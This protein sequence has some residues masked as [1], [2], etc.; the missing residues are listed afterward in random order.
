MPKGNRLPVN[1]DLTTIHF[2]ITAIVSIMHRISG[3]VLFLALPFL[4]C[5]F[6]LSVK[7]AD[8]FE[9]VATWLQQPLIKFAT[10]ALI[11]AVVYHILAGI[12]HII[13]DFGFGESFAAGK[14]SAVALIL[15][16][17]LTT[18]VI[19]VYLW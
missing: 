2:P 14:K 8:G 16:S 19:G 4:M 1:L 18:V 9:R 5:A 13:M 15:L 12:R 11:L 17:I 3:V 7:S 10:L 6:G